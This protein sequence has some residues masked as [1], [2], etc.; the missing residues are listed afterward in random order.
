MNPPAQYADVAAPAAVPASEGSPAD[1]A[2]AETVE[3]P[4]SEFQY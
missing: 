2:L 3:L 4:Y 1:G